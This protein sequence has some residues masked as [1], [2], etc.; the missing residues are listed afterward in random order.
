MSPRLTPAL[1]LTLVALLAGA[2]QH[3]VPAPRPVRPEEAPA[4]V[5]ACVK[6]RR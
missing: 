3:Q 6:T 4:L 1:G 5:S 2:C